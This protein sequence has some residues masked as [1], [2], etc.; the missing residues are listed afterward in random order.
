[1]TKHFYLINYDFGDC[2]FI[3]NTFKCPN[4]VLTPNT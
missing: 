3:L 4:L 2:N 1:M